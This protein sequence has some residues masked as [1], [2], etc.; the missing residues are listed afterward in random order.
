[1]LFRFAWVEVVQ[2]R[3]KPKFGIDHSKNA[4]AIFLPSLSKPSNIYRN[5]SSR[6][7]HLRPQ[8]GFS[9]VSGRRT[10][11]K[12]LKIIQFVS[13]ERLTYITS[14]PSSGSATNVISCVFSITGRAMRVIEAPNADAGLPDEVPDHSKP[15]AQNSKH[16]FRRF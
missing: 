5:D 8:S 12:S 15:F 3:I 16:R 11:G 10:Y 13:F 7:P 14:L 1:M 6:I 4:G 2:A 9:G